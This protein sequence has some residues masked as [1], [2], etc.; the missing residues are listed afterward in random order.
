MSATRQPVV[1]VDKPT[2]LLNQQGSKMEFVDSGVTAGHVYRYF[3]EFLYKNGTV[4]PGS[5]VLVEHQ[6]ETSNV[7]DTAI[8]NLTKDPASPEVSFTIRSSFIET[9]ETKIKSA[10]ERQGLSGF[11]NDSLNRA[12]LQRLVAHKVSRTNLM[13]GDVEEFGVFT[14]P[15]FSDTRLGAV[16]NV[17]PLEQGCDY[18]Y[19]IVTHFRP[20]DSLLT[21]YT[22]EVTNT[23]TPSLSYSYKPSKWR[24]PVTLLH[25]NLVSQDSLRTNWSNDQ[26]TFGQVGKITHVTAAFGDAHPAIVSATASRV[27][28]KLTRIRWVVQGTTSKIDHFVVSVEI[29]GVRSVVGKA[30]NLSE[31]GQ[32]QFVDAL[33]NNERGGLV[34]YVLPV[35]HDWTRGKEV[36]TNMVVV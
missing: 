12:D 5:E 11:F 32:Y 26:F 2:L 23:Q 4:V 16:R 25:G 31:S 19:T 20:A 34:Y 36:A 35:Y 3:C 13:T 14:D 10:L 6:P 30:H 17:S 18:R 9:N 7:I 15:E 33:E 29:L 21:E 27:N 24:H 28:D 1:L 22:Q 8:L